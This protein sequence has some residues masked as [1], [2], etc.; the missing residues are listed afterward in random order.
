MISRKT[1]L[2]LLLPV[3]FCAQTALAA[4]K[5][6]ITSDI[7]ES[8]QS[9]Q[10]LNFAGSNPTNQSFIMQ[11]ASLGIITKGIRPSPGLET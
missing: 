7:K 2:F 3:L 4:T 9:W 6:N 11:D 8:A 10:K 5:L 1:H